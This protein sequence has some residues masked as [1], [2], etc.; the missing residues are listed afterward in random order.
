M[1][2]PFTILWRSDETLYLIRTGMQC[3]SIIG[4]VKTIYR[5]VVE[6]T[7]KIWT[8][9]IRPFYPGQTKVQHQKS[10][11]N[12]IRHEQADKSVFPT[13]YSWISLDFITVWKKYRNENTLGKSRLCLP[14]IK[15]IST[16][17]FAIQTYSCYIYIVVIIHSCWNYTGIM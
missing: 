5:V 15:V 6:Q 10:E 14:C 7:R 4:S 12:G 8:I 3:H 9:M 17:V 2:C 11:G 1:K 13:Y 16:Q